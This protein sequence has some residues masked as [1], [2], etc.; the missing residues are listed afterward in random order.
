[1]VPADTQVPAEALSYVE[2]EHRLLEYFTKAES[3][4]VERC[5]GSPRHREI[6]AAEMLVHGLRS[7]YITALTQMASWGY[8]RPLR[9]HRGYSLPRGAEARDA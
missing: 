6:A 5:V 2:T 3:F 1:M 8:A 7:H 4:Y 9:C